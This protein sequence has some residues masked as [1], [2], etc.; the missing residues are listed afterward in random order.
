MTK[1]ESTEKASINGKGKILIMDDDSITRLAIAKQLKHIKYD[2]E[3][4]K[5]S[6]EAIALYKK[7]LESHKSFDAVVMDLT[8][9]GKMGG[10]E[11]TKELLKIDPE[12][13]V[14]VASGYVDDATMA[15]YKKF[16]FNGALTKPYE[17]DDLEGVLQK[18][19]MEKGT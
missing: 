10:K 15:E 19:I 14:I 18:V 12:A 11:A 13:K 7:A 2:V 16:G 6:T 1:I 3:E 9:P 17:I 4:A 5:D 8:I